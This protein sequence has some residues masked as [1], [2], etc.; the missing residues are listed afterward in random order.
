M[1]K[2]RYKCSRDI[3]MQVNVFM[4]FNHKSTWMK[5]NL[6]PFVSLSVRPSVRPSCCTIKCLEFNSYVCI[7]IY[8][9]VQV[10]VYTFNKN[11]F[12]LIVSKYNCCQQQQPFNVY[13]L[14]VSTIISIGIICLFVVY[15]FSNFKNEFSVFSFVFF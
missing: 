13:Y 12:L 2:S 10:Q 8:K 15:I 4:C 6:C 14:F 3:N 11:I 1:S 9:R 7:S 5:N